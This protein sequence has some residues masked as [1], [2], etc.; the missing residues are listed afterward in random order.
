MFLDNEPIFEA[1]NRSFQSLMR[2]A[3]R[4]GSAITIGH[5]TQQHLSL[6]IW[7]TKNRRYE[8]TD[9]LRSDYASP[10]SWKS[11]TVANT[12]IRLIPNLR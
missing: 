4:R 2:I 5:P 6:G 8:D 10:D 11:A 3:Q 7:K 12:C 9:N 1:I